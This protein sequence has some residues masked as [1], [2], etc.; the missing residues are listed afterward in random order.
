LGQ[1]PVVT[2]L[3]REGGREGGRGVMKQTSS[4]AGIHKVLPQKQIFVIRKDNYTIF[5]KL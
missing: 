5:H 3:G 2:T 1:T 4:T